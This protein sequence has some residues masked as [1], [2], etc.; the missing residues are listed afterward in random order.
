LNL[1]AYNLFLK[2]NEKQSVYISMRTMTP[3]KVEEFFEIMVRDGQSSFFQVHSEVQRPMVS[4]N[5]CIMN[6]G[7]IYAGVQEYI[8]PQSKHQK[9]SLVLTNFGNLPAHFRWDQKNDPERCI[10]KFEPASGVI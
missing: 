6:L 3:E 5:R 9:M 4:L 1:D 8:N 10:V 2:P 7:R